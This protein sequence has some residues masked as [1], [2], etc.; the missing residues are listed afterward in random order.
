MRNI[1]KPSV[2]NFVNILDDFSTSS[3]NN[4]HIST[5]RLKILSHL[6]DG[7]HITSLD[8]LERFGCMRLASRISELKNKGLPIKSRFIRTEKG[9]QVKEYWLECA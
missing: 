1:T 2:G 3:G 9:K 5:Q 4:S 7:E 8:A 6:K